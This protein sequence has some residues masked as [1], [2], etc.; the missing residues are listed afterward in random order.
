MKNMSVINIQGFYIEPERIES[1]L[2]NHP[3]IAEAVVTPDKGITERLVAWVVC[4]PKADVDVHEIRWH[5]EKFL[6]AH[7]VPS[8]FMFMKQLPLNADGTV[9]RIALSFDAK[10][11]ADTTSDYETPRNQLENLVA[12]IWKTTLGE[13]RIGIHD[14]FLDLGGDSIQAGLVSL[15]IHEC[16]NVE[17]PLVMFFEDMTVAKLA[18]AI[19]RCQENDVFVPSDK[20]RPIDRNGDLPL[21]AFQEQLLYQELYSDVYNI[22]SLPSSAWFSIRLS[23]NLNREILE[24]AFNYVINRHEVFR[25]TYWPAFGSLSPIV[26]KWDT[27]RQ[28]CRMNPGL[29]LP[30][31]TFKQTIHPSV[32]MNYDYYDISAYTYIDKYI[33]TN[34]VAEKIVQKRYLYEIPPLTRAALIK[35]T[36][37]EHVLIVAAA[38]LIVD[39]LSMTIYEKELA[40]VYSELIKNQSVNLPE[41]EIQYIDYVVWE[42]HGMKNGI[43]DSV[44]SYWQQQLDGYIP[45][46]ATILPFADIEN[47]NYDGFDF[48]TRYIYHRISD[49][50]NNE[51]RNYAKSNN[52]TIFSILLTGFILCLCKISSRTDIG[53]VTFFANRTRS[54]IKNVIGNFANGNIIRVKFREDDCLQHCISIVAKSLDDA[55]K[56]Q[57]LMMIPPDSRLRKSLCDIVANSPITCDLLMKNEYAPFFGLEVENAIIELYKSRYPLRAFAIDSGKDLAYMFQYNLDLFDGADIR[58]IAVL[59]EDIVKMLV[60]NPSEKISSVALC[61]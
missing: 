60:I 59:T 48:E 42:K 57:K 5:V 46:D 27:V 22:P 61:C 39:G 25:T 23:G 49:D 1:V 40:F 15:K 13:E 58:R 16:F 50:I 31:V 52:K 28:S 17:I 7:M 37:N 30:K 47:S 21:S 8:I 4:K 45:T 56:N 55:I 38:H 34:A 26:D 43:F 2:R 3:A 51:I 19:Y 33:A 54:E 24:K 20:I 18:E 12:D 53:V 35:T 44:R 36:E 14:D 6:S 9:D 32:V 10:K 29:F 41:P 11:Y